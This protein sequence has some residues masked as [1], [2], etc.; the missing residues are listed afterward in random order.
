MEFKLCLEVKM[1]KSCPGDLDSPVTS[2]M[3]KI[4]DNVK[5]KIAKKFLI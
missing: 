4:L 2:P 1:V 3:T 5:L